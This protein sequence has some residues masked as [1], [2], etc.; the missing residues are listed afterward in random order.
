MTTGNSRARGDECL[1]LAFHQ[2]TTTRTAIHRLEA[3]KLLD[4]HEV[5][6]YRC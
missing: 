5:T 3:F 1:E 2:K 4:G 6:R